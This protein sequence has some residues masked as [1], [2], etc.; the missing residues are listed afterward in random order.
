MGPETEC[1]QE[2]GG[3]AMT[4]QDDRF[5]ER[6][7]LLALV[8]DPTGSSEDLGALA[9]PSRS[10]ALSAAHRFATLDSQARR[11]LLARELGSRP[12]AE[13][14]VRRA[15]AWAS[16]D[17]R[18]A[19]YCALPRYVQSHFPEL[20]EGPGSTRPPPRPHLRALGRRRAREALR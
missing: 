19:M 16:P 8:L 20:A 11:A 17:L 10:R 1:G 9:E 18:R 14:R 2:G 7:A 13:A 5:P 6:I 12:D 15:M 3:V 4:A